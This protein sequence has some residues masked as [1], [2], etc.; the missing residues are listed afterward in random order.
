MNEF[1]CDV[2]NV[3]CAFKSDYDRHISSQRHIKKEKQKEKHLEDMQCECGKRYK[4]ASSLSFHRKTCAKAQAQQQAQAHMQLV[5]HD[6]DSAAAQ[7]QGQGKSELSE[8]KDMVMTMLQDNRNAYC[9][10]VDNMS[11]IIKDMIPRLG[12]GNVIT[13]TSTNNNTQFNLNMFL[14]EEC[15]DAI[16]LSDFVKTLNI[17]LH[18]LEYTKTKGIVEGVGSIIAN[19]LR[20]MDIHKR[21][22][23]CTDAKR[24]TM[25]VKGDEWI[26]DEGH[27][28]LRHF[29]Y[30][31]S[32]Y[33]T[34][35]IQDWMN[36]H[37][38]WEAKDAMHTEYQNICK[39]L[40][41]NIEHDDSAHKKIIKTFIKDVVQLDKQ[42]LVA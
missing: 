5:I 34:R 28:H 20:G 6:T 15:K 13:N 21:P 10:V 4:F 40:Y 3:A 11:A 23:H 24:E 30:L 2:C 39:E 31:T 1:K 27:A 32:C 36:A 25:Y 38:G 37:P 18:D 7:G 9:A 35:V 19:N 17:T 22:I 33:Q 12:N 16:K 29:I 14:N 41:K 26:K 8:F 42:S